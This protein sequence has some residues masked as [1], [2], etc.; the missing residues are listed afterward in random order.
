MFEWQ[1]YILGTYIIWCN[2]WIMSISMLNF[3]G[4]VKLFFTL[5]IP[6]STPQ[7]IYKVFNNLLNICY[8]FFKLV[9][10]VGMKQLI[11]VLA[12]I[13][14][15]TNNDEHYFL[16]LLT[17]HISSLEKY[18]LRSF[19]NFLTW[20]LVPLLLSCKCSL[21]ILKTSSVSG[22]ICHYFIQFCRFSLF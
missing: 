14:L 11:E 13:Y 15:M 20:V 16:F 4:T 19:D 17:M 1:F 6:F 21:Y 12:S 18:L 8:F 10:L 7:V 9:I 22:N 2:F 5:A 3:W